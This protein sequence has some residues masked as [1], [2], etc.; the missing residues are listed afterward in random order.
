MKVAE[1]LVDGFEQIEALTPVD[2]LRRAKIEVDIVSVFGEKRVKSSHGVIVE[3]EKELRDV[4]FDDYDMIILPGGPGTDNYEKSDLFIEKLLKY[5]ENKEKYIAAICAA[6]S[7]LARLGIL[8]GKNAAC[9]PS[10]EDELIKGG[11][12]LSRDK[13]VVDGTI[14]TSRGAGTALDFSLKLIEVLK[15]IEE[16]EKISE[17]IVYK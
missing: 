7:V 17:T 10:V 15:G 11:A 8:A 3:T 6:P 14:I 5:S 4:N 9:F 16:A 2:L 12:V 13:V 1:F